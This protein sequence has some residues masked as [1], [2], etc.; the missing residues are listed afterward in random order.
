MY[1]QTYYV[2]KR[3]NTF[4]D[5]LVAYGLA[6]ILDE[7]IARSRGRDTS[8]RVWIRD[9]GPYYTV[10]LPE[11]I[12]EAWVRSCPPFV[13]AP[14]VQ[15]RKASPPEGFPAGEAAVR[16]YEAEW[17]RFHA[18]REARV[19]LR[20]MA[21]EDAA[22]DSDAQRALDALRPAPGFWVLAL[23]GDWRMQAISIYNTAVQQWWETWDQQKV[24]LRT[25][26]E[27]C[28]VPAADLSAIE[29]RWGKQI[30]GKRLKRVLS[31]SQLL[32]PHRGKGQNRTK[33]NAL[34]MGN[35]SSFWLLEHLKAVGLWQCAVPRTVRRGDDRKTY[36][37]SPVNVTLR[38][39]KAVFQAFS[40]RL[41]SET[42]VKMDCIASLLYTQTLLE[43]SEAGQ[44][45]ELD[46][47]G[48]GPERVVNGLHVTQYKLLSRNAYTV[49]NL[50]FIGLPRWTE[51]TATRKQVSMLKEV[52]EEHRNIIGDIDE[53]RSEGYSLLLHYRDFLSGRQLAAFFEFAAG[54]GQYLT[55]E[56][57]AGRRWIQ[58]FR[59]DLLGRLI[60]N[61]QKKLGDI[62]EDRGFQNVAYA[63]RYST[64]IPQGRKA[65]NESNLYD[66][67]YGLGREL[68]QKATRRDDL[69]IAL[70]D[71]MQS[72]NA[73]N[74]QKLENTGQQMRRDLR[75]EDVAAVIGLV[76][77]HGPQ[78]VCSLL[79]AY[80]YARE[81]R[82]ENSDKSAQAKKEILE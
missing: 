1:Q 75:T 42:A 16:D 41:W 45:N 67:R 37:L 12:Q 17:E 80:G 28:A 54:Y 25:I 68:K 8:R 76:D 38:A 36:A 5:V 49:L 18:Y 39:H 11:P 35:E 51:E 50:A 21:Q 13:L 66:I 78:V 6:T 2:D 52:I 59:T 65:R 24:N 22:V 34:I 48:Y 82:E 33:A 26:L 44:Y 9:A 58:P 19:N 47:E 64:I 57:E 56:W 63:I 20:K 7:V 3:T 70:G 55:I 62:I 43:Y 81:P 40:D 46:F 29:K 73:E 15:T 61:H 72:Y 79:V 31:A 10:E 60:V 23:V 32:N 27:M 69:V 77:E 74:A 71:F 30:A 14:F 4:A 53:S